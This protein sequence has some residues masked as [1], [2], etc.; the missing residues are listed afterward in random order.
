M[1]YSY[2][3]KY[4][5]F[6][7]SSKII[8]KLKKASSKK[9][10]LMEVCGTHTVSIFRNGIRSLIPENIHLLSGPGCP[11]CVTS[12]S[13]INAFI[14]IAK[15]PNVIITTFGDLM[16]VPGSLS[17]LQKE[18]G[19][20]RDIRVIYSPLD[21][22]LIAKNNPQK[23]V[24]MLGVG[25]ETTIPTIASSIIEAKKNSISNYFVYSSHKSIPAA[26]LYLTGNI[27][28]DG[29]ILPGHV[30]V[31]TGTNPYIPLAEKFKIPCVAAGFEPVD[32]L[33]AIYMLTKQ[34][35]EGTAN[36]ENAYPRGVSSLGNLKAIKII[37]E[38]FETKDVLWR[39][40]GII[41]ESGFKIKK[42]YY[43][44]DAEKEFDIK[45][46]EFEQAKGCICGEILKGMKLPIECPLYKKICTPDF[47]V[48]PCM[49]SSEGTCS[50]Y[51]KYYGK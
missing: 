23:K 17:S 6:E 22:V 50:A 14:E 33:Q 46:A 8:D 26:L 34:I 40:L 15:K 41:P 32:I 48:G 37:D 27:K 1:N 2:L 36:V 21:S 25:F 44:F 51:Y 47:P 9:I 38:V 16:R 10:R 4:R 24:V 43:S 45:V 39:G 5:D 35:E 20:G 31:I 13:D 18:R 7:I 19:E 12:Q 30:S 3:A 28:I 42:D 49:V 29:Y 11:V